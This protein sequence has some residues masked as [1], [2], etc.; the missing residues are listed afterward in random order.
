MSAS[1][2]LLSAAITGRATREAHELRT[3]W[4]QIAGG[5]RA[6]WSSIVEFTLNTFGTALYCNRFAVG[7]IIELA[8]RDF[9]CASGIP[10]ISEPSKARFDLRVLGAGDSCKN[11][12]CKFV[13]ERGT[14]YKSHVVLYN[15]QRTMATDMSL[16]PTLLFL[17]DEWWF[18][19]PNAIKECGVDIKD[20]IKNTGDSVHLNFTILR[21]LRARSYPYVCAHAIRY[22]KAACLKKPTSELTYELIKD[23]LN[24]H[25]PPVIRDYLHS[26][27]GGLH[28]CVPAP[29]PVPATATLT[30]G[31]VLPI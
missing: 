8:S 7:E 23:Y 15:A 31:A 16:H 10:A 9:L 30:T 24:P 20:H 12:S 25:T 2:Q 1:K 3:F 22:D 4:E 28:S 11:I 5:S 14:A 6:E 19:E 29:V 17:M 18:L 21:E 13:S 26:K 27:I